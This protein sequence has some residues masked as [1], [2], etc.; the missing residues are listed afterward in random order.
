[1]C[2]NVGEVRFGEIMTA[3]FGPSLNVG[4]I[5]EGNVLQIV[6]F[7]EGGIHPEIF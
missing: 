5:F 7:H 6:N 2:L 4:Q 1:V 3:V